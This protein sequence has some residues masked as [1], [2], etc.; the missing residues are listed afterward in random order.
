[1]K[2]IE[3]IIDNDISGV[4][5]VMLVNDRGDTFESCDEKFLFFLRGAKEAQSKRKEEKECKHEMVKSLSGTTKVCRFGCGEK[6]I[7][8]NSDYSSFFDHI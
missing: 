3:L 8:P 7:I 6:Y 1:M 5:Y 4:C 2:I